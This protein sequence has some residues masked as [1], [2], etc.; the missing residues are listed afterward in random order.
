MRLRDLSK[1]LKYTRRR[2]LEASAISPD[3]GVV[4][5]NWLALLDF[6]LPIRVRE[7]C[8]E[9][10]RQLIDLA[11]WLQR[12]F[13]AK[14]GNDCPLASAADGTTKGTTCDLT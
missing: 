2:L 5:E 11:A 1:K 10:D 7:R 8:E 6:G 14:Y 3:T 4:A 13:F 12:S 9:L